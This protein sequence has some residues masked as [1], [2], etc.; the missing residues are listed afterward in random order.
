[1]EQRRLACCIGYALRMSTRLGWRHLSAALVDV[2]LQWQADGQP[3]QHHYETKRSISL[4]DALGFGNG[5]PVP[6][7]QFVCSS[8]QIPD[9]SD[10][11]PELCP[12]VPTTT[13]LVA[14]INTADG[15][16]PLADTDAGER[17]EVADVAAIE[18]GPDHALAPVDAS[19]GFSDG[20]QDESVCAASDM[21]METPEHFLQRHML[22]AANEEEARVG[23]TL[24]RDSLRAQVR[25]LPP[26]KQR[27]WL[28]RVYL[29]V[30]E[31]LR[32]RP[33][34]QS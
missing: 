24:L 15:C 28:M 14:S 7:V 26:S 16:E 32:R 5:E 33:D 25:A 17:I 8:T 11:E 18:Q 27:S 23:L 10:E 9:A 31:E 12:P 13:V 1:M 3:G 34:T 6:S 4:F 29:E 2:K 22:L 21:W 20:S 19:T 30:C